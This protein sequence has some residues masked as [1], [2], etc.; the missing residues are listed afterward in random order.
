MPNP[1]YYDDGDGG[2]D[3]QAQP[4]P[5]ADPK[6]EGGE[7]TPL[8]PKSAFGGKE[9]KPGDR[10]EFEVVTVHEDEVAVKY[11]PG[12]E[13]EDKPPEDNPEPA[14]A[15]GGGGEMSSMLE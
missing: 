7:Q 12:E 8:L 13:S 1:N 3:S 15:P 5:G 6:D 10:C 14:E 9:P 11:V 4:N 2:G